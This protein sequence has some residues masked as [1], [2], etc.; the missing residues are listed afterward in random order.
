MLGIHGGD[1]ARFEIASQS[2]DYSQFEGTGRNVRK[3]HS[4][5]KNACLFISLKLRSLFVGHLRNNCTLYKEGVRHRP[6]VRRYTDLSN[7]ISSVWRKDGVIWW[8]IVQN[9]SGKM[10]KPSRIILRYGVRFKCFL[11][12]QSV[13]I[14]IYWGKARLTFPVI[15]SYNITPNAQRSTSRPY[16]SPMNISGAV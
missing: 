5:S 11:Y 1:N 9:I 3:A 13:T 7:E 4:P 6:T 14:V 2:L 10:G 12:V 8:F 16:G 15:S